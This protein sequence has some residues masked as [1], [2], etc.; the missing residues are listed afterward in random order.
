MDA[1]GVAAWEGRRPRR[2]YRQPCPSGRQQKKSSPELGCFGVGGIVGSL[3]NVGT[4][5]K[6]VVSK[7]WWGKFIFGLEFTQPFKIGIDYIRK[8]I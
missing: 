2:P 6:F 4:K 1:S 5:G 7:E 3:G 8:N